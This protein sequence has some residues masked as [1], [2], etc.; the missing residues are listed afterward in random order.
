MSCNY[1]RVRQAVAAY[2]KLL[3]MD[4]G[5]QTNSREAFIALGH[6]LGRATLRT[7]CKSPWY[8]SLQGDFSSGKELLALALDQALN[9]QRYP[10]GISKELAAETYL[11]PGN[12]GRPQTVFANFRNRYAPNG[13]FFDEYLRDFGLQNPRAHVV[14]ASNISR[15]GSFEF[16]RGAKNMESECLD[17]GV[18]VYKLGSG[19]KRGVDITFKDESRLVKMLADFRAQE[20]S[21]E[22]ILIAP[23][24]RPATGKRAP[25]RAEQ[26]TH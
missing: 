18:V 1:S 4:A 21:K 3:D 20:E 15:P 6:A 2:G 9:P 25:S 19:F 7:P 13:S 10:A 8:V 22:S 26:H 16:Y 12:A 14:I 24:S 5:I 11:R 17:V 23:P